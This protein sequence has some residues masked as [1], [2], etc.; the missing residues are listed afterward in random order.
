MLNTSLTLLTLAQPESDDPGTA[1]RNLL[2][3]IVLMVLYAISSL[4]KNRQKKDTTPQKTEP[5]G[6]KPVPTTRQLPTYS[7]K[8]APTTTP[9][10]QGQQR[11][12]T[13]GPMT[14]QPRPT[15]P[16]PTRVPRP[17]PGT[18]RPV[19]RPISVPRMSEHRQ[20][21]AAAQTAAGRTSRVPAQAHVAS[22]KARVE[23]KAKARRQMTSTGEAAE[24]QR[25]NQE[26]ESR[27]MTPLEKLNLVLQQPT[28][29]ARAIVS[30]EIIGKPLSLR[31]Q[32]TAGGWEL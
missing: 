13:P 27:V 4:I 3:F 31:G 8:G 12:A 32:G 20:H 16:A 2:P 26:V 1:L 19:A 30:A 6:Q 21:R 18:V 29:L 9:G 17:V 15:Q 24:L 28:D 25:A 14:T 23:N 11:P 10:Q 5:L 22:A 7:R